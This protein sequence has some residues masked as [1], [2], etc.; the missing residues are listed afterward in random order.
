MAETLF[1]SL[2]ALDAPS[3]V[4]ELPRGHPM[5]ETASFLFVQRKRHFMSSDWDLHRL[6]QESGFAFGRLEEEA[7]FILWQGFLGTPARR[8]DLKRQDLKLEAFWV[9]WRRDSFDG[10]RAAS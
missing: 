9:F 8:L 5:L 10:P 3:L 2:L 7:S 6:V 1:S 4:R